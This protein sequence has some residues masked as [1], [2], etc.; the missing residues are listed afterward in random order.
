MTKDLRKLLIEARTYHKHQSYCD[1]I[2]NGINGD[3]P[4]GLILHRAR[5]DAALPEAD[6]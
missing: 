3:C 1:Q 4:C 2:P 6:K 5:I